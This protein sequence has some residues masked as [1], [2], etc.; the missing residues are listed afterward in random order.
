MT[1][2][3]KD[4]L[5]VADLKSASTKAP[6]MIGYNTDKRI[7]NIFL[8]L[9]ITMSSNP[10]IKV[11]ITNEEASNFKTKLTVVKPRTN[12]LRYI[13][14]THMN[15]GTSGN[16]AVYQFDLP[17]E[18]TDQCGIYKCELT[19]TCDV[20]GFEEL[21]TCDAFTYT[22]KPSV[23]TGLNPEIETKPELPVLEQ[24]IEEVK[25]LQGQGGGSNHT[26]AKKTV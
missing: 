3:N 22:I 8:K 25:K 16:G 7:F 19:V 15:V 9:Q 14:G 26:H 17:S 6:S 21:I 18:F 11:F 2:I 23:V 1:N 12:Q 24:L 4:Y 5:V 10:D 13:E 20:N